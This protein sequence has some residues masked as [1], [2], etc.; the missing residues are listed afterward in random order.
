MKTLIH[1]GLPKTGSTALQ[2]ALHDAQMDLR[3]QG[4]LYPDPTVPKAY[5][6]GLLAAAMMTRDELPREYRFLEESDLQE[7]TEVFLEGLRRQIRDV[8]HNLLILSSEYLSRFYLSEN[9]EDFLKFFT[10]LGADQIEILV[11]IRRPSDYYLSASQQRL[12]AS[13]QLS[14]QEPRDVC[15]VLENFR[16]LFPA[17]DIT[18]RLFD[19]N[20]LEE[21]DVVADFASNY[22]PNCRAALLTAAQAA[23]S[24]ESS[25]AEGMALLQDYRRTF[26]PHDDDVFKSGSGRLFRLLQKI[27]KEH[28]VPRPRLKAEIRD[29]I[30]YSSP[31]PL[32]LRDSYGIEFRDFDY[33]R[34]ERGDFAGPIETPSDVTDIVN[35]DRTRLADMVG[36]LAKAK[37]FRSTEHTIWLQDFAKRFDLPAGQRKSNGIGYRILSKLGIARPKRTLN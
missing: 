32:I 37:K 4:I 18:V 3:S 22:A 21:G 6:H 2:H 9:A 31:S 25:S 1:I 13:S 36:D 30:D 8:P 10:D 5:N 35:V 26:F 17:A 27:E 29:S 7:R 15:G 20:S 12:R 23:W 34:L 28:N 19:R 16:T 11:Y 33:G 24:N 14:A